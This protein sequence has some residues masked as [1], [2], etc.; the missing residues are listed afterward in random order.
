MAENRGFGS[1]QNDPNYWPPIDGSSQPRYQAPGDFN[2]LKNTAGWSETP[3]VPLHILKQAEER[4]AAQRRFFKH[5][6]IYLG[7][8]TA[9]WLIGL[10]MFVTHDYSSERFMAFVIPLFVTLLGGIRIAYSYFNAFVWLRK[11]YQ[12]RVMQEV[13]K[14]MS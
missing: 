8:I 11:S 4:V 12:E 3:S 5:F 13:Q 7:I 10:S 2:S 9:V 6:F 1:Y 14:I